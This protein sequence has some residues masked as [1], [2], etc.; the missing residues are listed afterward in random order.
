MKGRSLKLLNTIDRISRHFSKEQREILNRIQAS[1]DFDIEGFVDPN[2]TKE[3]LWMLAV[4]VNEDIDHKI[5]GNRYLT[6]ITMCKAG[7]LSSNHFHS[8]QLSDYNKLYKFNYDQVAEIL[9]AYTLKVPF[10]IINNFAY[11]PEQMH[12]L[13]TAWVTGLDYTEY[14]KLWADTTNWNAKLIKKLNEKGAENGIEG[15][16]YL[17]L[18][19]AKS[20]EFQ[21]VHEK[22]FDVLKVWGQ[23]RCY[24]LMDLILYGLQVNYFVNETESRYKMMYLN[25]RKNAVVQRRLKGAAQC[26]EPCNY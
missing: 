16:R 9:R 8:L 1:Y 3:Q 13:C 2:F 17:Y 21:K 7:L 20:G 10:E 19:M 11:L 26:V 12:V 6:P 24:F 4:L 23:E 15:W 25:E 22:V 18:C 14:Q 5:V